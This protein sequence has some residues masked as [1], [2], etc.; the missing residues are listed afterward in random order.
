MA[1]TLI[2]GITESGKTTMLLYLLAGLRA[3]G[4]PT[5]AL[6]AEPNDV[7]RLKRVCDFVTMDKDQFLRVFFAPKTWGVAAAVDEGADT[8]GR[9]D[10]EMR[11]MATR[12]RHRAMCFF[13]TQRATD[14]NRTIRTQCRHVI[15]FA[16]D[17]KDA[18]LLASEY[19]HPPLRDAATLKQF[20]YMKASR[21]GGCSRGIIKPR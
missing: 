13:S 6:T 17:G 16:Q 10:K 9:Y 15:T 4:F 11:A 18:E 3:K 21:F 12:G 7:P 5:M 1:H 14:I 8:I 2:T 20:E 19:R